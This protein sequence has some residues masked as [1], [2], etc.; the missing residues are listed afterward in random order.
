MNWKRGLFRLWIIAS[1]FWVGAVGWYTYETVVV[2][3]QKAAWQAE[4]VNSWRATSPP[5][6]QDASPPSYCGTVLLFD[7]LVPVAPQ[8]ETWAAL[9]ASFPAGTFLVWFAGTWI[10]AGFKRHP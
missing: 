9:S 3:R 5:P 1:V 6:P 7:D 4:C 10:A 2:P 8:V